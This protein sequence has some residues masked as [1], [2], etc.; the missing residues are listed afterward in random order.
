MMKPQKLC[1]TAEE[2]IV[3]LQHAGEVDEDT[4]ELGYG[5]EG[6]CSK[7]TKPRWKLREVYECFSKR[8]CLEKQDGN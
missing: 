3:S 7:G 8:C 5:A 1:Y 2:G 4:R 6:L